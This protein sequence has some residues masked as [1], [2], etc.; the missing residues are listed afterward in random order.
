MSTFVMKLSS[1]SKQKN[2][3]SSGAGGGRLSGNAAGSLGTFKA[4]KR[5]FSR[6]SMSPLRRKIRPSGSGRSG[7]TNRSGVRSD[8][9]RRD[10]AGYDSPPPRAREQGGHLEIQRAGEVSTIP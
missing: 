6:L 2:G 9:G 10:A 3:V 4:S 5:V 1:W 7:S 8:T